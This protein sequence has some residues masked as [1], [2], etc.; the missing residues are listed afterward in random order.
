MKRMHVFFIAAA[1]VVS[2]GLKAQNVN[3]DS[4]KLV[5]KISQDQLALGQLQNSL[6]GK[7]QDKKEAETN[8]QNSADDNQK[9]AAQLAGSPQDK[10]LAR[11]ASRAASK[12]KGDARKA[13][14]ANS[15]LDDLN[16]KIGKLTK[17]ISQEQTKLNKYIPAVPAT[18]AVQGG[19]PANQ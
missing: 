17:K 3:T 9:A 11:Q 19:T 18:P 8:A 7:V 6:P 14:K 1:M 12:A 5:S 4:L 16:K 10:S 15:A 2:L 13:R